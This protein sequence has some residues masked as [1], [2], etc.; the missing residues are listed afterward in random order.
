MFDSKRNLRI[1]FLGTAMFFGATLSSS[2]GPIVVDFEGVSASG[3]SITGSALDSYLSGFGITIASVSPAGYPEI[4]DATDHGSLSG[5]PAGFLTASSGTNFLSQGD[6]VAGGGANAS[7]NSPISYQLDFS[8]LQGSVSFTR[9]QINASTS[10]SG[11]IV[12]T[13][14]ARALDMFGST[15][16]TVGEPQL[17]SFGTIAAQSFTLNG[18]NIKSLVIERTSTNTVAGTNTVFID[19]LVLDTPPVPEPSTIALLLTGGVGL[20]GYG[21]RRKKKLAV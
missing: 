21:W 1:M 13:W 14:S 9:I 20:I 3:T 8:T 12:A 16:D 7:T 17:S 15:L 10:P 18:P 4:H 19:D 6:G 5:F 11:A 2:A